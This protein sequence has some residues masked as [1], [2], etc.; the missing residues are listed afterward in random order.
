MNFAMFLNF[1]HVD[2][3]IFNEQLAVVTYDLI[4]LFVILNHCIETCLFMFNLYTFQFLLMATYS[5]VC[6]L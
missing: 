2:T 5:G 1:Y 3:A 4:M 6:C